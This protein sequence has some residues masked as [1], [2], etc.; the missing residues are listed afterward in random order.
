M[1]R[2]HRGLALMGMVAGL[3][4]ATVIAGVGAM[5]LVQRGAKQVS[6]QKRDALGDDIN[7]GA[8]LIAG[9]LF[10]AGALVINNNKMTAPTYVSNPIWKLN[11]NFDVEIT[12]CDPRVMGSLSTVGDPPN[13][14]TCQAFKSFITYLETTSD[15]RQRVRVSTTIDDGD[16]VD[17]E[18]PR[19]VIA[20]L[21]GGPCSTT[22][23]T[24]FR[25][26]TQTI[27]HTLQWHDAAT[28]GVTKIPD[29]PSFGVEVNWDSASAARL[30][31]IAGYKSVVSF[32]R[33]SSSS[34]HGNDCFASPKNNGLGNWNGSDWVVVNASNKNNSCLK[35]LTCKDPKKNCGTPPLA[36]KVYLSGKTISEYCGN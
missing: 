13:L 36:D 16:G 6:A 15:D 22:M 2:N 12:T 34:S 3:G 9:K 23:P 1:R 33:N 7:K 31:E 5:A 14:A 30:C 24:N 21:G 28:N 25:Y 32:L 29:D 17:D 20:L 18:V 4:A 8:L 35:E 19:T 26:C 11:A 10:E 27:V